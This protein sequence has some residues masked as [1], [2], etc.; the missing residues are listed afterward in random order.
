MMKG[1]NKAATEHYDVIVVGAGW[2]G[3]VA[4]RTFTEL[5]PDAKVL[6]VDDGKTVGG[7]WSRERIYPGLHAQISYPL[8]EYS[9]YPMIDPDLSYDGFV[10]GKSIHEYLFNFARDHHLLARI[11]L[12]TR[13]INISRASSGG[14]WSLTVQNQYQVNCGKLIYATGANSSPAVPHWPSVGFEKPVLHSLETKNHLEFIQDLVERATVVGRSKSAYDAVYQL[15]STGKEVDWVMRDGPSGPFSIYPPTFLGLWHNADH[16]STRLASSFSPCIMNTSGFCYNFLQ[17]SI[18][19]RAV[20]WVYWRVNSVITD[21]YAG[22]SKSPEAEKLRPRPHGYGAFWG[23]GGIGL[24]TQHDFWDVFHS[25]NVKIHQT[26][27]ESFSDNNVVNLKNGSALTTDVVICCTGFDKGFSAFS[28]EL[29]EELGLSYDINKPSK[30]T[31]LDEK[32]EK[33]VDKMLP[34]LSKPHSLPSSSNRTTPRGGPTRHYRRLVVPELAA[35][36]DRS[37]LFP[38]H[39]H[40][41]FTPLVAEIQA[42]WGVSWMLGLRDLP[43]QEEME[44]EVAA[45]NAWTR[46]RYLEQGKKHAYF[47]YDYIPYIDIL[48]RDLGLNPRRKTNLFSEMCVRYRPSDY[49]GLLDEYR[50]TLA[51]KSSARVGEKNA[52][53][54]HRTC[55]MPQSPLLSSLFL[56]LSFLG[57]LGLWIMAYFDGMTNRMETILTTLRMPDGRILRST[58]TGI[59]IVDWQLTLLTSFY[60]VLSNN[61]T[62]GPRLLFLDLNFVVACTNLWVLIESRRGRGAGANS[63]W[64]LKWPVWAIVLWNANGAAIVQPIFFWLAHGTYQAKFLHDAEIPVNEAIALF[65]VTLPTMASPL[66]LFIPTW[67]GSTTCQHHGYIAMFQSSPLVVAATFFALSNALK[68]LAVPRSRTADDIKPR[69]ASHKSSSSKRWILASLISVGTIAAAVHLITV[70]TALRSTNPDASWTRLFIPSLSRAGVRG[71]ANLPPPEE[72]QDEYEALVENL[73][74]FSQFDWW[75][76]A[77]SCVLFSHLLLSSASA[78]QGIIARPERKDG[79]K[80]GRNHLTHDHTTA[81]KVWRNLVYL[82]V[83]S[84]LLGP[85]SAGSFALVVREMT[86]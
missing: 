51:P 39:V 50:R 79:D 22:Y 59:R 54:N 43:E 30:W 34:Y 37:I 21:Q 3:L 76:V 82:V 83:G 66:L 64:Y 86:L 35:R 7:V 18:A 85:G 65:A 42:L 62:S 13:V 1:S 75:I 40:S 29:R 70:L 80:C 61:L 12:G 11:R 53:S 5:A 77:A 52:D 81:G 16:I 55:A 49:R 47:I 84:V 60:E 41:P 69:P 20:M 71:F 68:P 27:I 10:S 14:G 78:S 9:F 74:L 48:M 73:H 57:I 24:A 28:Q 31:A 38:G 72:A 8:F 63:S 17:R 19:G 46:K 15:L 36:G 67:L 26:E 25:G 58:Y 4:A 6:I 33:M 32:G 45:F 23:S 56:L 44:M 2:Y